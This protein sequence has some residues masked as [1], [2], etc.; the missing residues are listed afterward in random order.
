[1]T[2]TL[3]KRRLRL[4][5]RLLR[6][7]RVT[8]SQLR[9]FLRAHESTMPRFDVLAALHRADGELTMT[10]LSRRLLVSNGNTTTVIDRLESDGLVQ[11]TPSTAD[12]R[13]NNVA[14]TAAGRRQFTRLAAEHEAQVDE[15]FSDVS[16]ADL[17]AL[18]DLLRRIEPF[19]KVGAHGLD[20]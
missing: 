4:W 16:A 2:D 9:E 7:T 15:I 8:E 3:A 19:K 6:I 20:G 14:L 18:E 1:M 5:I 17:D 10:E 13:I 11:R 12:R